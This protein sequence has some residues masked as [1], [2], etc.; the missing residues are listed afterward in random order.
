M[1]ITCALSYQPTVFRPPWY[2]FQNKPSSFRLSLT[3]L[4][5][6]ATL[7][8]VKDTDAKAATSAGEALL[9]ELHEQ[10]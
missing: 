1:L 9:Q 10:V 7:A 4:Q 6:R 8:G 2:L 3:L 5:A